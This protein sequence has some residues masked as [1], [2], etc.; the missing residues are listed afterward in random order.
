MT[1]PAP[2]FDRAALIRQRV[3]AQRSGPAL[4]LHQEAAFEIQEKLIDVNRTFKS[5][6]VVT[7]FPEFWKNE[8]PNATIV[9][10]DETLALEV[11]AHDLV[12]HAMALHWANDPVGQLIQCRR[13]L[14]PDGLLVVAMLGGQTLQELRAALSEAEIA[15]SGGLSP[16]ISPMIEIRDAG[17][18][19]QRAGLALPVADNTRRTVSY[20]SARALLKDLRAMGEANALTERRKNIPPRHLFTEFERIYTKAFPAEGDR[21]YATFEM[22]FLTGWA[23]DD[24]QPQP[25]R[26]GSANTRL[27]DFLNTAELG[28][29]AKPVKD[30][31][32]KKR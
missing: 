2:L 23:P 26:P 8:L 24:S 6:A 19:L 14:K 4:F 11:G 3:R 12:V 15:V 13:A 17:A 28:E 5:P 22:I 25:L 10:D 30:E 9:A 31:E 16:R 20:A 7:G 1:E 27:A 32:G 18:L 21:V 29:D